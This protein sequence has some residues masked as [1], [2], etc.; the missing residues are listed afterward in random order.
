M[1]Q[2]KVKMV[3]LMLLKAIVLVPDGKSVSVHYTLLVLCI[4]I[5]A[6]REVEDILYLYSKK[7]QRSVVSIR[8]ST[9]VIAIQLHSTP[10]KTV[11]HQKTQVII[12]AT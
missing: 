1:Q 9:T 5:Q 3:H 11:V 10:H 6:S 4:S 12:K 2:E 8:I 7:K